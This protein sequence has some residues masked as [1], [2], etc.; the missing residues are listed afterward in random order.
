MSS[1]R[2]FRCTFV[3]GFA[4]ETTYDTPAGQIIHRYMATDYLRRQPAE[5]SRTQHILSDMCCMTT[6]PMER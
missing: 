1:T 6:L 5:V 2:P 3:C 4:G